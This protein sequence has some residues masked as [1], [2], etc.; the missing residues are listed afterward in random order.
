MVWGKEFTT[1]NRFV[2]EAVWLPSYVAIILLVLGN[3]RN[4]TAA[5]LLMFLGLVV[6][7]MFLELIYRMAFGDERLSLRT[8]IFAVG[9]QVVVWG[10]FFAWWYK[11]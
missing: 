10:G 9:G 1:P 6:S 3:V 11:G 8:G 2:S 7:R 4:S 5:T